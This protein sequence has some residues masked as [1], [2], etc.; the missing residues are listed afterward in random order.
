[1]PNVLSHL[2]DLLNSK[3]HKS[4][5]DPL[6]HSAQSCR[7]LL[8]SCLVFLP[9]VLDTTYQ[10]INFIDSLHAM[11]KEKEKKRAMHGLVYHSFKFYICH[12][13][14]TYKADI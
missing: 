7:Y 8:L 2:I 13:N 11:Q 10:D 6:K 5:K 14:P 1:M 3:E 4:P 9:H 12:D